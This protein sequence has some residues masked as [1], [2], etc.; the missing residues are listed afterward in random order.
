MGCCIPQRFKFYLKFLRFHY[1]GP[2]GFGC[3]DN[4]QIRRHHGT[5]PTI[6]TGQPLNDLICPFSPFGKHHL[7]PAPVL[8]MLK[9]RWLTPGIEH[10]GHRMSF[11]LAVQRKSSNK[12]FPRLAG[13]DCPFRSTL[14][15]DAQ[16]IVPV[17]KNGQ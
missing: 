9:P 11:A 1:K 14:A 15:E 4:L 5:G 17:D 8:V 6:F 12:G 13:L 10:H 16:Y 3:L 2:V 7:H